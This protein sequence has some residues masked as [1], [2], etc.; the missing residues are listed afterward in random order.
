MALLE[1]CCATRRA[2]SSSR[3]VRPSSCSAALRAG[4]RAFSSRNC[5]R[6]LSSSAFGAEL[7]EDAVYESQLAQRALARQ[8]RPGGL[9]AGGDLPGEHVGDGVVVEEPRRLKRRRTRCCSVRR[10]RWT[11][12]AGDAMLL[13]PRQA[14]CR[15]SVAVLTLRSTS[16]EGSDGTSGN[17][18]AVAESGRMA[19]RGREIPVRLVPQ[20]EL[21]VDAC[22]HT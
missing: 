18:K 15:P 8:S 2:I 10:R 19:S 3:A 4:G 6:V 1:R 20:N 21:R 14:P 11:T 7:R 17:R 22:A 16:H 9:R 5:A 12:V 13:R